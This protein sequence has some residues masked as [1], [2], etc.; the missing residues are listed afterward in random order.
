VAKKLARAGYCS[1]KKRYFYGVQVHIVGCRQAS[2]LPTPNYM[3]HTGNC[4][5]SCVFDQIRPELNR[6]EL[7]DKVY[8]RSDGRAVQEMQNLTVLTPVKKQKGQAYFEPQEQGVSTTVS[9]MRLD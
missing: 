7:Y 6:T 1:T 9:W 5:D 2:M 3:R 4:H 8:Q